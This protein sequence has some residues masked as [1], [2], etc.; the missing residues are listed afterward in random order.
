[1]SCLLCETGC[2]RCSAADSLHHVAVAWL[3]GQGV[4]PERARRGVRVLEYTTLDGRLGV[5]VEVRGLL[6]SECGY[7]SGPL[8][9]GQTQHQAVLQRLELIT[10]RT[11]P[12]R[13]A[14]QLSL[15][16]ST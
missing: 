16:S 3:V 2:S 9:P 13:V 1:V 11:A 8:T 7:S 12:A 5:A 14:G 6:G 15:W 10:G 4:T